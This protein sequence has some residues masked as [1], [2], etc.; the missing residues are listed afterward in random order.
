MSFVIS[1]K[2]LISACEV[3]LAAEKS[4]LKKKCA[5]VYYNSCT[6]KTVQVFFVCSFLCNEV[7]PEINDI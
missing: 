1:K 2:L 4:L 5:Q 3:N 6:R 7:M